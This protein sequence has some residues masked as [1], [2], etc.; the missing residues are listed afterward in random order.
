[1]KGVLGFCSFRHTKDSAGLLNEMAAAL[2]VRS[3]DIVNTFSTDQV[4]LGSIRHI[5]PSSIEQPFWNPDQSIVMVMAGEIFGY[6]DQK[7][8]LRQRGHLIEDGNV[9]QFILALYKEEGEN[10]VNSLNGAFAI[11]IWDS[12]RQKLILAND[13]LG[14]H[15]LYY[16]RTPTRFAFASG[17][18]SLLADPQLS[19]KVNLLAM[20]QMLTYDHLLGNDTLLQDVHLLPPGSVLTLVNGM[21]NIRTYWK[22]E[23]PGYHTFMPEEDYKE[24][25]LFLLRQAIKRQRPDGSAA[26]LLSGGLDSRVVFALLCESGYCSPMRAV[27]FGAP[28]SDD[29]NYAKEL[30]K[31][32]GVQHD[33]YLLNSDYLLHQAE[34]GIQLSDGMQNIIH[35]HTLDNLSEQAE[36]SQIFYKGFLGDALAGYFSSRDFL[37]R[38]TPDDT[39][40]L[41]FDRYYFNF[42]LASH[43]RLFTPAVLNHLQDSVLQSL[44]DV[45][46]GTNHLN[47]AAENYFKFDLTQRQRRM[48]L[49]GVQ[50]VRS[51][52]VVR[53]P[54]YDND[55]LD[56]MIRLPQG[57]RL[58]RY[59]ILK[60]FVDAFPDLAKIPYTGTGYPLIPGRRELLMRMD[61]H[62]RWRLRAAGLKSIPV[63]QTR[64][65]ATYN[66]WF[67]GVLR[68]WAESILLSERFHSRGYFNREFIH[69]LVQEHMSG[70]NHAQKLGVLIAM[71]LWHRKFVD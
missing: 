13:R 47:Q 48:T 49:K 56:F 63:R 51:H 52:G 3:S 23:F 30:A 61:E 20:G 5:S 34:K 38:Y 39:L 4:G 18:R 45:L 54:F 21:V 62:I 57:Y 71:E 19:R 53:T 32:R 64:H 9:G 60:V 55:L 17:V 6:D 12:T 22:V 70:K 28:G 44:R 67:R 2:I 26:V 66:E 14:Y 50:L 41:L 65:Y 43:P 35:M 15:P 42:D 40:K 31:K 46:I 59:L 11:S 58:D 1:M 33:F 27:T 68:G 29:V 36:T 10:F 37:T 16:T 24:E 69:Q 8:L 7:K 25:L